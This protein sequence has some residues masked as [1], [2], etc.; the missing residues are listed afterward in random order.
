MMELAQESSTAAQASDAAAEQAGT[1]M[2]NA[3]QVRA[4]PLEGPEAAQ[5]AG[6]VCG[7]ES[8]AGQLTGWQRQAPRP[9]CR[10]PAMRV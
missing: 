6:P 10:Q 3:G 1:V 4:P 8:F 9:A 5:T 2:S 7:G